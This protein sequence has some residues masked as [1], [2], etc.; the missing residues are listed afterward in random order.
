MLVANKTLP[1]GKCYFNAHL[2]GPFATK[3]PF[4]LKI[5]MKLLMGEQM[6][7]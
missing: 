3:M 6:E 5:I 2:F 1:A 4:L 7:N